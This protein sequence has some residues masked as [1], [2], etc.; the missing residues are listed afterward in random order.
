MALAAVFMIAALVVFAMYISMKEG[1]SPS[2]SPNATLQTS[3]VYDSD[4]FPVVDWEY[5]VSVNPDVVAWVTVPGTNIDYPIVQAQTEAPQF[6]LTHDVYSNYN[7]YGVPYVDSECADGLRSLNVYIYGHHMDDGAMFSTFAKY[8]DAEFA[9]SNA[10]ILLQT[11]SEK[12]VLKV[13]FSRVI[14]GSAERT[15]IDFADEDDY[16]NWY[17]A[18]LKQATCAL[19]TEYVPEQNFIFVTC[20]YNVF[21]NERTLVYASD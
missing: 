7:I 11:P 18:E 1:A 16:A 3:E 19:D 20:S 12:R 6:Y 21:S 15:K 2:P 8:I 14:N 9:Q 4:G 13:R 17:I 10:C 5:W